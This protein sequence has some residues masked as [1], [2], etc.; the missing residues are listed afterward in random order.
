MAWDTSSRVV[1]TGNS[2]RTGRGLRR[3]L[4]RALPVPG[5]D[6]TVAGRGAFPAPGCDFAYDLHAGL[7]SVWPGYDL[8]SATEA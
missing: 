5:S 1:V 3:G 4:S 8:D 6:V 7:A 2:G